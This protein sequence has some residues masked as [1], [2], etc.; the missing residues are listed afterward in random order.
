MQIRHKIPTI[1]NLSM[2][3][4]L[5]CALG[6]CI[7]LWLLNLREAKERADL[8]GRTKNEL[9]ET[10]S[11]LTATSHELEHAVH[12]AKAAGAERDRLRSE[13]EKERKDRQ[14]LTKTLAEL[15]SQYA[16]AREEAARLNENRRALSKEKEELGQRVLAL[17]GQVREKE[18]LARAADLRIDELTTQ[19]R[20]A[21][22]RS[23][24]LQTAVEGYR[25]K[26]TAAEA[27]IQSAEQS[28]DALQ[29]EKKS[30]TDLAARI[31]TSTENRFEGIAL[32]GRRVIFLVDMSGSMELV[33][34]RTAAP[35]KWTAVRE[36]LA[37]IMRSLPDLEKFQVILFS[38]KMGYLLGNEG[39]WLDYNPKISV[40]ETVRALSAIKPVG[41]TN[42]HDGIEA[43]FRYRDQGL[44][45]VYIL[46][47]GLP[48]LGPGITQE[49]A[50]TLKEV[51]Q[52]EIL[53]RYIRNRLRGEWNREIPGQARVR[54]HTV[55]F[56]FESPDVGAFLWAL[57]RENEGSFVGMSQ[58]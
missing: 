53:A 48:N 42:M 14:A 37:K 6:C 24:E 54:I 1:F 34:I 58:P 36:T 12:Q 19:L 10:E 40:D 47:D 9:N 33:D 20:Q 45:T 50:S 44:D 27:K 49:Q 55:G 51:E 57:A 5:C 39:R 26:L 3:D 28:L 56:F 25:G 15:K 31:R 17:G 22:A 13:L 23:K 2:V 52:S 35:G 21:N 7:L 46:S 4:V 32:T 29:Q 30:L 18:G 38:E 16:L 41:G 43:A 8:A 11:K